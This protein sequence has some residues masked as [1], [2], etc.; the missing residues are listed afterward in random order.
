VIAF[1][2]RCIADDCAAVWT[3]QRTVWYFFM[4]LRAGHDERYFGV[5]FVIGE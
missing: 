2:R 3:F 1:F 4:T 5:V